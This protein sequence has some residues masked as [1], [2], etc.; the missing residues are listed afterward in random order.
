MIISLNRA[1]TTLVAELS[2]NNLLTSQM[3]W[4]EHKLGIYM[5]IHAQ[6]GTKNEITG[7]KR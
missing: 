4:L 2:H 6:L 5:E 3:D 7:T 1:E